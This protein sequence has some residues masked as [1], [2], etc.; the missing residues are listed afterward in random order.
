MVLLWFSYGSP[1]VFLRFS[2]G[3]PGLLPAAAA[4]PDATRRGDHVGLQLLGGS[5]L[6][7]L[8]AL[9]ELGRLRVY[10]DPMVL[11]TGQL[12]KLVSHYITGT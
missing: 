3:F 8:T 2:Y 12:T 9:T 1:M 5:G 11:K 7:A 6:T 4:R 10:R